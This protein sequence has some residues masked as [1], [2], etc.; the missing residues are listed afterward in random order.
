MSRSHLGTGRLLLA[1]LAPQASVTLLVALLTLVAALAAGIVPRALGELDAADV[2]AS[3]DALPGPTRDVSGAIVPMLVG[4]PPEDQAAKFPDPAFGRVQSALAQAAAGA[5]APLRRVLGNPHVLARTAAKPAAAGP[6]IAP[7]LKGDYLIALAA[8]PAYRSLVTLSSGTMPA[9]WQL[10]PDTQ[11]GSGPGSMIDLTAAPPID[12][13]VTTG[14]SRAMK[15]LAVGNVF[16]TQVGPLLVRVRVSGI[17]APDDPH[18]TYWQH[19][20]S[21][22]EPTYRAPGQAPAQYTATGFVDP[23]TIGALSVFPGLTGSFWYPVDAAAITS[24]NAPGIADGMRALQAEQI[25]IPGAQPGQTVRVP[26]RSSLGDTIET[27]LGRVSAMLAVV[28]VLASGPLGVVIAVFALA[29]RAVLT[30]RG[31][32]LALAA[33]RG[34]S[35]AQLRVVAAVEGLVAGLPAAA[36]GALIAALIIPGADAAAWALPLAIGLVPAALFAAFGAGRGFRTTRRDLSARA[37]GSVRWVVEA[38]VVGGAAVA[39]WLLLRRGP[40]SGARLDPLL[41]LTPL[42]LALAVSIVVLRLLPLALRGALALARRG[43]GSVAFLGAARAMRD[44]ALGVAAALSVVVGVSVA[45]FSSGV[46]ASIDTGTRAHAVA[47]VGAD[48]RADQDVFSPAAIAAARKAPGVAHVAALMP[49]RSRL[50]GKN[51]EYVSVTPVFADLGALHAVRP[52]IRTLPAKSGGRVPVFVSADLLAE[53]R[54]GDELKL[55]DLPV[56]IA[57][58]LP[59]ASQLGADSQWVLVDAAS[60]QAVTGAALAPTRLLV[61]LEPGASPAPVEKA[62]T[63]HAQYSVVADAAA[64]VAQTNAAP[65]AAGLRLALLVAAIGS[66]VLAALAVFAGSV[67]AAASRNRTIAMLRTMGLTS[68]QVLG[69][70]VWEIV[71]LVVGAT[72][73][74]LALGL[75]LPHVLV[76][77]T[78]LAPFTG[79]AAHLAVA[80]DGLQLA[81]LVVGVLAVAAVATLVAV[82]VA[83]RTD[84][85]G[86]VKMGAE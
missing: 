29:V 2:R 41:A 33:A 7:D 17:V 79:G 5:S 77:A 42:L 83:R 46:L 14:T 40:V 23:G 84:P 38:C 44:P 51:G 10:P 4:A 68:G 73:V 35:P 9:A 16:S 26:V 27:S 60:A 24:A 81:L 43:R 78:D 8:D 52:D 67:T 13:A 15:N 45:V 39:T 20:V 71:P 69:L 53:H 64:L 57:G 72:V 18:S 32:V 62:I 80:V 21:I 22:A 74:G 19:A 48:V 12:M 70:V 34:A 59:E 82:L 36:I 66:A 55:G 65:T 6:G 56:V 63:A 3:V 50:L 25:S 86:T 76:A 58:S 61:S 75:A 28:A 37:R 11:A 31:D 1:T 85:V 30:R 49:D 54:V 47:S